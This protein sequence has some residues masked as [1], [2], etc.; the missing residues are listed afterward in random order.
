[1]PV[2]TSRTASANPAV[3][4]NTGLT[5]PRVAN[6]DAFKFAARLQKATSSGKPVILRVETDA[7]HGFGSTRRQRDLETAD[8]YAFILAQVDD[9][10]FR[11][12]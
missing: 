9:P 4:L 6:W 1:M 2:N 8:T 11:R 7:G 5:D 10:R 12:Q 3:M